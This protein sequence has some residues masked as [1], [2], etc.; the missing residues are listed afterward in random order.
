M[1]NTNLK[2]SAYILDDY[3]YMTFWKQ[4]NYGDSKKISGCQGMESGVVI[5]RQDTEEF[6]DSENTLCSTIML[7]TCHYSFVQDHSLRNT[8]NDP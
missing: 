8:K 4:Q 5:N 1:K 2:I 7:D 3:N 6:Q